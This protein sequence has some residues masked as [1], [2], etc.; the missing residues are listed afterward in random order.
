MTTTLVASADLHVWHHAGWLY[1]EWRCPASSD[2]L[3]EAGIRQ[4][5]ADPVTGM[6]TGG[7]RCAEPPT[8]ISE[9]L[10]LLRAGLGG[11]LSSLNILT[12]TDSLANA[13]EHLSA[14]LSA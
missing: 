4:I 7:V 2:E 3:Y 13:A 10:D 12:G 6:S 1:A 9:A 8:T 5:A 11:P 14:S